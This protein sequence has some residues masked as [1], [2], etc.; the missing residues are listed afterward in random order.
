ME[1]GIIRFIVDFII[2]ALMRAGAG[3]LLAAV[4]QL[5]LRRELSQE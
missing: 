4:H 1:G 2:F 3:I 5:K